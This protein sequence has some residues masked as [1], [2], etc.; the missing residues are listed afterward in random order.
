[1]ICKEKQKIFKGKVG[2]KIDK[3][4]IVKLAPDSKK[5]L[6]MGV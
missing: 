3:G 1:M 2:K 5:Y 6:G 4:T